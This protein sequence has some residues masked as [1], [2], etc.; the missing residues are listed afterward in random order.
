MRG[1]P[2]GSSPSPQPACALAGLDSARRQPAGT[3]TQV[4]VLERQIKQVRRTPGDRMLM[5][6]LRNHL[7]QSA[8]AALLVRP[9]AV[10]GWHRALVRRK[11]A[12]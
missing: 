11:W 8:R 1:F 6:A 10:L 2:S 9:E 3:A 12:A 4:Q 7:P 5:A